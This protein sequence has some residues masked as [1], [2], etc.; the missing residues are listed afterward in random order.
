MTDQPSSAIDRTAEWPQRVWALCAA[1]ALIGVAIQVL[2]DRAGPASGWRDACYALATCL[3]VTGIIA[4]FVVQRQA[5]V[6]A[7]GFALIVGVVLGLIV[8][9]N[10]P[11]TPLY[12]ADHWRF[13]CAVLAAAIAV[14]LFQGWRDGSPRWP[15][16]DVHL[17]A[18]SGVVLWCGAWLFV[19]VVWALALLLGQLFGLIGLDFLRRLLGRDPVIWALTGAAFG[20]GVGLLRD[21]AAMLGLLQRVVMTILAV[22]APVLAV[23]LLLFLAALPFTGLAPLWDATRAT[24]PILLGCVVGA[25]VLVNAVIGD[26]PEHDPRQA[27]LRVSV[28][29]LSGAMLPLAVIAAIST[30]TRIHQHGLTPDRLWALTFT[31]IACAYAL[32]YAVVL[33]RRRAGLAPGLR[34]ANLRLAIG[35]CGLALVLST[36]LAAFGRLSAHDQAARL[37][38]GVVTAEQFDWTAMRFDYG[39]AGVAVLRRLAKEGATAAVRAAA[40]TALQRQERWSSV[41]EPRRVDLKNLIVLPRDAKLPLAL[42]ARLPDYEAC[43][44]YDNCVVM[45]QPGGQE[46]VIVSGQRV[47]RWHVVGKRW[48]AQQLPNASLTG[49]AKAALDRGDVEIRTVPRRQVFVGGQPIGEPFE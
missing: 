11:A 2:L 14:P 22:L 20:A 5:I 15:Y 45:L 42:Q 4:A 30:G 8:W 3:A 17:Y 48:Q 13:L 1:G 43:F 29:I 38:R 41:V 18:W 39:P 37:A 47:Q 33:V 10:I 36:P 23:G 46:A 19:A 7:L 6:R 25:L 16:A 40:K 34:D 44:S 31:A 27:I 26:I 9:W 12:S 32:A 21:R 24:T 49:P 35:M 28:M